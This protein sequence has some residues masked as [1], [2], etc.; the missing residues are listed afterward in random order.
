MAFCTRL[1]LRKFRTRSIVKLAALEMSCSMVLLS[2]CTSMEKAGM[3]EYFLKM[4]ERRQVSLASMMT[5]MAGFRLW[6]CAKEVGDGVHTARLSVD[7][8]R[9]VGNA[10]DR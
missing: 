8:V 9:I 6:S 7:E 1:E 3:A 10:P 4:T 2:D 5:M